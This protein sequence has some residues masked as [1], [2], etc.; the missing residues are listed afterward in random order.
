MDEMIK[1][2]A[3]TTSDVK[4]FTIE[5]DL[6]DVHDTIDAMHCASDTSSTSNTFVKCLVFDDAESRTSFVSFIAN[7]RFFNVQKLPHQ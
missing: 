6:D 5:L 4:C 2:C 1:V 7:D 3:S